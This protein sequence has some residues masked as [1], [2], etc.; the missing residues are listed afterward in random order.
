ME[1]HKIVGQTA[2]AGFQIGVRRTLN[3]SREQAWELL[4]SPE[5]R[6]LWL[7]ECNEIVWAKGSEFRTAAGLTGQLRVVKPQEQL[8]L[9]WQPASW[10]EA[11]TLQIRL[12][13]AA[14]PGRTTVSFHQEK[15][16]TA[17]RREDMKIHWE[18]VLRRLQEH[19]PA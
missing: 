3:L 4:T 15:L 16:D 2:T 5:G 8:R 6:E 13:P 9:T 12:L 18:D 7:G 19:N 17:Q 10:P 1:S 14:N 11:S